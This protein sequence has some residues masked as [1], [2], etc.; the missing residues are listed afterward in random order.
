MND[1]KPLS[2]RWAAH[3]ATNFA[4]K[5]HWRY[6]WCFYIGM[7]ILW[8]ALYFRSGWTDPFTLVLCV[9]FFD[10]AVHEFERAGFLR[11]IAT[12]E[13]ELAELR[14]RVPPQA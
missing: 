9:L 10:Q 8:G 2:E 12:K 11:L 14:N 3:V 7:G 4:A 5:K 6:A 13:A 1:D